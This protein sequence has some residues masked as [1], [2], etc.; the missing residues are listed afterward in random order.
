V[1]KAKP[2]I[3]MRRGTVSSD[4]SVM[5][6]AQ[7]VSETSVRGKFSQKIHRQ[8]T[9]LVSKPP[10]NGPAAL[11]N[12]AMPYAN[13]IAWPARAAGYALVSTLT[14]TGKI[15][16]A[17]QIHREVVNLNAEHRHRDGQQDP[18]GPH[19]FCRRGHRPTIRLTTAGLALI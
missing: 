12:P 18:P 6:N 10:I 3:S 5:L 9:V 1:I 2:A 15:S 13:P 7:M 19:G 11:P 16:A 4:D 8:P 14:E 17:G